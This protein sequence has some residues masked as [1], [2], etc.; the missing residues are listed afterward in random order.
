[1]QST[2]ILEAENCK[3][4]QFFAFFMP[5]KLCKR[6][7]LMSQKAIKSSILAQFHQASIS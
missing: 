3:E 6:D 7:I 4:M 1:L 5:N 2:L